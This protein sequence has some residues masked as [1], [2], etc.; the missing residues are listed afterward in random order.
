MRDTTHCYLAWRGDEAGRA[1]HWWVEQLD[2][3]HLVDCFTAPH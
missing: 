1:L 3:P 2:K